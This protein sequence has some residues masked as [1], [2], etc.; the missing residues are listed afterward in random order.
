MHISR[1]LFL[2]LALALFGCGGQ[3]D[4]PAPAGG[5]TATAP[6][7]DSAPQATDKAPPQ[8]A[9]VS[10]PAPLAV[11]WTQ[12]LQEMRFPTTP[13]SGK[14]H[15][16]PFT[17]QAAELSR[18]RGRFLTL[19]QGD[20]FNPELEV[21]ILLS[22]GKDES[23]SG[24]TYEVAPDA[25]QAVPPVSVSWKEQERQRP[26]PQLFTE[27]YALRLE[28]GQES[29]G[30]LSGKVYLSLPDESKSV[31]A[32]TFTAEVEPDY[33][34]PPRPDEAPCV[35]GRIALKGQK[36][37]TVVTGFIGLT[38]EGA[39]I[40]NLTGTTVTPGAE[41]SVSSVTSPPQRSSLV[42]DPEAGCL[43]RHAR[44]TPGRYLVFVGT[45]ERYVDW[46][47]IEV[48]DKAPVGL[49]FVLEPDAAGTLEVTLPKGAKDGVRLVPLDETGK[50]PDVKEAL[51]L[52]SLAMK[53][54]V[55]A[56]DGKVVL[57]GLRPG[58]Y[59]VGV[60]SVEKDATVKAK[61]TVKAD[62]S[63]S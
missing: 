53:T 54:D 47:W 22:A 12:E 10:P 56:K 52:L 15:G 44:L 63:G 30:K 23:F 11:T 45:G 14:V 42:N 60:G 2:G 40:S 58:R 59:R 29:D 19:R 38:A 18:L 3:K 39:P 7:E 8:N 20:E 5:D 13:A 6:K 34:K 27:K 9:A 50:V 21:K 32:G 1:F 17:P 61:E 16:R 37:L 4:S 46:R 55:D 49:D 35:V 26:E 33:A 36:E 24:K 25:T 57:D 48:R 28:F 41:T 43:C 31:V 51:S 62:L